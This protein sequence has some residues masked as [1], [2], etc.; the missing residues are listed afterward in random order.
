M[1]SVLSFV[2]LVGLALASLGS[3]CSKPAAAQIVPLDQVPAPLL[4]RAKEELPDVTFEQAIRRKDGGLEI[5]GKD[6]KGKVRDVEFSA[7]GEVDEV[8]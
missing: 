8:E 5:R 4:A 3:G 7:S 6:K 1:R 2:A